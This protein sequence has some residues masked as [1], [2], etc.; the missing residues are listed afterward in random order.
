VDAEV[1]GRSGGEGGEGGEGDDESDPE[2]HRISAHMVEAF[3]AHTGG[4]FG[5]WATAPASRAEA[6]RR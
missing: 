1:S 5:T 3:M 6:A 4:W 2:A